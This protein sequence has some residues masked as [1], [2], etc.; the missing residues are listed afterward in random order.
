V[1]ERARIEIVVVVGASFAARKR[2][3]KGY[4]L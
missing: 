3:G 4:V 2:G 1:R